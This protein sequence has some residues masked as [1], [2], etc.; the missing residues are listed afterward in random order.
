MTAWESFS[1][2]VPPRRHQAFLIILVS[3]ASQWTT[4]P[5]PK[6]PPL[7]NQEGSCLKEELPSSDEEGWR[8]ERRGG[9]EAGIKGG[10]DKSIKGWRWY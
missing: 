6:A 7:L 5:A 2:P 8:A 1:Q 4:T 3:C 9:A 10:A